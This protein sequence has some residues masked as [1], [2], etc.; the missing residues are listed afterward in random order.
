MNWTLINDFYTLQ[1]RPLQYFHV[2]V[3]WCFNAEYRHWDCLSSYPLPAL[4][5]LCSINHRKT[6]PCWLHYHYPQNL[7]A[8]YV[9]WLP[10]GPGQWEAMEGSWRAKNPTRFHNPCLHQQLPPAVA[11]STLWLQALPKMATAVLVSSRWPFQVTLVFASC[12][13]QLLPLSQEWW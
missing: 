7:L 8:S 11:E 13:H 12:Q 3:T 4:S 5:L 6:E 10:P 2:G 9:N 1:C